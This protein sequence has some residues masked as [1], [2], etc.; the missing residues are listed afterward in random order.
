M[1]LDAT[2]V[3]VAVSGA[4]SKI[5]DST[6]VTSASSDISGADTINYGYA[7]ADGVVIAT[8]RS[9]NKITSWQNSAVVRTAATGGVATYK[10][11]LL[12]NTKAARELYYGSAEDTTN[13]KIAWN[14]SKMPR[15]RFVIDYIDSNYEG[16]VSGVLYGR[17]DIKRGM[18]TAI[19]D[20]SYKNGE[21]I[22]FQITITAYP[23]AD[24]VVADVYTST[25]T[26]GS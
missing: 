8:D 22:G 25:G 16:D 4:I 5:S 3:A 1:A 26:V 20:M 21:A 9:T 2:E 15:G 17:H 7:N 11:T 14:V 6:T 18:V 12:Q 13:G 23:D 10:F 24:G 19:G